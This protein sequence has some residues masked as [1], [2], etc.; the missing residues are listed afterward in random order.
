MGEAVANAVQAVLFGVTLTHLGRFPPCKQA[1]YRNAR[2]Y[3]IRMVRCLR[4]HGIVAA[5]VLALVV[6]ACA[7][8]DPAAEEAA[9]RATVPWLKRMDAGDFEACWK[10]AAPWFR[11]R[12][13]LDAWL[14]Q[15][16]EARSPL[17]A[18]RGRAVAAT[19]YVTNPMGAPDGRYVIVV[20]AS[21]WENGAIYETLSMQESADGRWLL[22]GYHA[23][24]TAP[25]E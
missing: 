8:H 14:R 19:T 20:Y 1:V 12:V 25:G 11:E 22:V 4:R 13:G 5:V 21:E 3:T 18:P 15:A 23:K 24:Q 6:G 10:A 17:G 7:E 2:R 9:R 16:A